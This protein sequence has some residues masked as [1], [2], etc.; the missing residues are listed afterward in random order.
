MES[1]L[2]GEDEDGEDGEGLDEG[3][4]SLVSHTTA[5]LILEALLTAL[6][7]GHMP[8]IRPSVL[9]TIR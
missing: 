8:P 4:D 6:M 1:A 3:E 7:F 5:C 2:A 9:A